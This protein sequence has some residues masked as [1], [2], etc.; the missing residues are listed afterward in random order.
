MKKFSTYKYALP[1]LIFMTTGIMFVYILHNLFDLKLHGMYWILS[2]VLMIFFFYASFLFSTF[3]QIALIKT[4][5][6]FKLQVCSIYP[7]TY[8]GKW[9]FHP[10]RLLYNV[11]GFHNSLHYNLAQFIDD[12]KILMKKGKQLQ[13]IKSISIFLSY[14]IIILCF[15]QT[16]LSLVIL[17][18]LYIITILIS[19]MS[20]GT[21]WYGYNYVYTLGVSTMKYYLYASKTIMILQ[22]EQYKK[23]LTMDPINAYF[24]LL[25]LDNY[26]YTSI[27]ENN[28]DI[29]STFIRHIWN[30][31]INTNQCFQ[32]DIMFDTTYLNTIKLMGWTG[33]LCDNIQLIEFAIELYQTIYEYILY[34]SFPSISKYAI[35]KMKKEIQYLKSHENI[36]ISQLPLQDIQNIF[37]IYEP[38]L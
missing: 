13:N 11:E 19:Y 24:T 8:D 10:I 38:I 3:I 29:S 17:F 1:L 30:A 4:F 37:S 31:N 34:N 12:D 6:V 15:R 5:Q 20:Y 27:Y 21:F 16:L 18:I 2:F 9:R 28:K 35:K 25:I 36:D 23:A 22:H 33:I 32:Y 14:A 26:L 7:F